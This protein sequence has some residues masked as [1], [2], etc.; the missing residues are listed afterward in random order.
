MY[1]FL[2]NLDKKFGR[3]AIKNLPLYMLVCYGIGYIMEIINPNITMAISLNPYAILHGQVWRLFTWLLIPPQ[4]E[5]LFFTLIAMYFYYSIGN[6]LE[7]TWGRFYFNYYIF[8]G[9]IFTILG[10]F[11]FYG[12]EVLLQN[13]NLLAS[14]IILRANYGEIMPL[15]GGSWYFALSSLSFSTYYINMSIFLAFAA[16]FPDV[17]VLLFFILPIKVKVLGIIYGV[18]LIIDALNMGVYSLFVVGASLLNF[19]IFFFTTR[20]VFTN[21]LNRLKRDIVKKVK[22]RDDKIKKM[23]PSGIS[24]HK[25]AICGRTSDSNPELQFRFCSKCDGNYEYCQDHLFSHTHIKKD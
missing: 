15:Y 22:E 14:E 17:Q 7:M 19:V 6:T 1:K 24:K 16:T 8:S 20:R 3:Y 4:S 2:L 12:Y 23:N 21:N 25:C 10:S 5:N 18:I 11:L 13:D 9:I